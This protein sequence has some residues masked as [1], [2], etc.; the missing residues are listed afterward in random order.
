[1]DRFMQSSGVNRVV[2]TDVVRRALQSGAV[3]IDAWRCDPLHAPVL[4]GFTAGLYR[5]SGTAR[6]DGG[7][8]PWS[9][10]LKIVRRPDGTAAYDDPAASPY[11]RREACAYESGLLENLPG[12]LAAPRCFGVQSQ[13]DGSI[14]LWLEDLADRFADRWPIEQYGLTA[15]HLGQF[16]GAY[17]AGRPLPS[18]PWLSAAPLRGWVAAQ[19]PAMAL[20]EQPG[21]WNHPL[22]RHAF[23]VPVVDRLRRLWRERESFL[24]ALTRLPQTLCHFDAG[25][26]NLLPRSAEGVDHTLAI[27]WEM[28]ATAPVGEEIGLLV[29]TAVLR[30]A[31]APADIRLLHERVFEGDLEGLRDAGWQV[32]LRAA[33]FGF[34]A[35]AA[36]RFVFAAPSLKLVIDESRREREERRWGHPLAEIIEARAALTYALLDLADEARGLLVSR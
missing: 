30:M 26:Q 12:G 19:A 1:M 2:L 27:D 36:L 35:N 29:S 3:E 20:V 10:V 6:A 14:V 8:L 4:S 28:V 25:P 22:L 34:A 33:R 5:L 7:L 16:N 31:L 17:L 13:P 24:G 11:W 32:D 18:Y 15:R 9:V 23:P 21:I